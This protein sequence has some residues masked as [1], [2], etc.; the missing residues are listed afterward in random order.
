VISIQLLCQRDKRLN[1]GGKKAMSETAENRLCGQFATG[2]PAIRHNG[3]QHPLNQSVGRAVKIVDIS[4]H[5]R[6]MMAGKCFK[7]FA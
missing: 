6:G 1:Y 7:T 4:P 5:C 2:E 3:M